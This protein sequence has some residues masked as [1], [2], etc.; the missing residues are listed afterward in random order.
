MKRRVFLLLVLVFTLAL[1][2]RAHAAQ[3]ECGAPL[4]QLDIGTQGRVKFVDGK[5]LNVRADA[6]RS[7]TVVGTLPEGSL[8]EVVF[9]PICADQIF[10]WKIKTSAL[11]GW[12]AEGDGTNIFVEPV[13]VSSTP[14]PYSALPAS[15]AGDL[16]KLPVNL[17]NVLFVKESALT[18]EQMSM[19]TQNGFVVVPGGYSQFDNAYRPADDIPYPAGGNIGD[20]NTISQPK[21]ITS[22]AMLHSLHYI[23]DN[24]LTDLEKNAFRQHMADTLQTTLA[25]AQEQA[26]QAAGTALEKPANNAVL[27]LAVAYRLLVSD[28]NDN[29]TN[30]EIEKQVQEL[31]ALAEKAEGTAPIPFLGSDYKE[32]FNQYRPRGHYAGDPELES[33]FRGMMWMGRITFLAK[34][35]V[36]NQTALLLLRALR[37]G[38]DAMKGWQDV[39]DLLTYLIG[40][41]D[42][43]GPNEYGTLMDQYF[44]GDLQSL[45]DANRLQGFKAALAQLPGPQINGMMNPAPKDELS[46]SGKGFR[47]FGQRFTLDGLVLQQMMYPYVGTAD[48]PRQLPMALD[49]ASALGSEVAYALAAQAGA[50]KFDKYDA[51]TETL[52]TQLG[53]LSK[54]QWLENTYSGWLW[55]LQP[56]VKRQPA[57]P[58]PPLMQSQAW[59]LKD[60]NTAL[61]SYTELKHDTVLYDKQPTGFGGGGPPLYSYGYVEP[62]PLVFDR[63][64]TVASLTSKGLKSRLFPTKDDLDNMPAPLMTDLDALDEFASESELFAQ[65]ARKELAGETIT[66]DEYF[67]IQ[68]VGE[69][70]YELL[71]TLHQGSDP[72][73]PVALVTDI[74]TNA[75]TGQVLQEG[76]GN[77]DTIFVVIPGPMGLQVARGGVFSYYEFISQSTR[78]TDDEW[79]SK[80]FPPRPNW[81]STYLNGP[82]AQP[83]TEPAG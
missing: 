61:G 16:P 83:T 15:Y 78:L 32:D 35:D 55:T 14:V 24:M 45:A 48:T 43:L 76:V 60:L 34:D 46:D 53:K 7:A 77:V 40:P 30:P 28:G 6:S 81:V 42:D 17:N 52:R 82:E 36:Q 29:V 72:I 5:P 38:K 51:Q 9:G 33:Y 31:V 13:E 49:V 64:A 73:K 57:S 67:A 18:A 27:Y 69:Y 19:L 26:N 68:Q 21:F 50:A 58:Y 75:T 8:F 70:L 20:G 54:E 22:D 47:F 25:A 39:S 63:M 80:P 66:G 56:L 2:G 62:N 44:T 65:I 41:V 71:E 10:W 4:S 1:V 12:V 74:A 37:N 79:R 59:W 3:T 23:F 11:Q